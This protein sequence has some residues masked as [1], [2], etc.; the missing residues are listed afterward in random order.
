MLIPEHIVEQW[1]VKT[2]PIYK[3]FAFIFQNPLWQKR[4]PQGF[5]VCPY[6]WMSVLSFLLLRPMVYAI[7]GIALPLI[8][9]G[10]KP[11]KSV[12]RWLTNVLTFFFPDQPFKDGGAG[13]LALLGSIA[14]ST[15]VLRRAVDVGGSSEELM[16]RRAAIFGIAA[17]MV[18]LIAGVFDCTSSCR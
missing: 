14:F 3:S 17:A 16:M 11:A 8:K 1:Y 9:L 10:G 6:F 2:H 15:I 12:D 7:T 4:V 18:V 5:S 13:I